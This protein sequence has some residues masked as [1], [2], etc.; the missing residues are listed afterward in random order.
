MKFFKFLSGLTL[1]VVSVF[2]VSAHADTLVN[3]SWTTTGYTY[4][5]N[6]PV[7]LQACNDGSTVAATRNKD[8]NGGSYCTISASTG[9]YTSGSCSVATVYKIVAVATSSAA[10]SSASACDKVGQTITVP[11]GRYDLIAAFCGSS[12]GFALNGSTSGSTLTASCR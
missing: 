11:Q 7:F 2:A 3:C 8:A 6:I 4:I 12:C 10:A 5:G 1:L 9:Y